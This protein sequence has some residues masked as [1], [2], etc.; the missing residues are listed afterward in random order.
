M[1]R[2]GMEILYEEQGR[3]YLGLSYEPFLKNWVLHVNFSPELW[4]STTE[5][6]N[7]I[8]YC[9]DIFNEV[10][11]ELRDRGIKLVLSLC[12]SEKEIK[13]NRIFGFKDTELKV[14]TN[15]GIRSLLELEL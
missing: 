11:N 14:N 15:E 1:I 2:D 5:I 10:L 7:I 6:Y 4:R 12:A 9:L 13:F 8:K 3:G